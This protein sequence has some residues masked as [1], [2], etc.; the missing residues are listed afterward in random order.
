MPSM[1]RIHREVLGGLG[2]APRPVFLDSPAGFEPNAAGIAEKAVEYYRRYLQTEL[3]VAHDAHRDSARPSDVA[4]AIAAIRDSNL[5]FAGPGSPTYALRQWRG[6]PVWDAVVRQFEGGGHVLFA[7]AAAIVLGRHALPVYEIYKVGADPYWN[8]GLDLLGR[9]GLSLAV[10][11]HF[12]D[13]SGG[14]NLDTRFCYMG[15]TRFQRLKEMLPAGVAVLGIDHYTALTLDPVRREASVSGQGHVTFVRGN[16]EERLKAGTR[17]P[18]EAL[19]ADGRVGTTT[20]SAPPSAPD[21]A[22]DPLERV[23][24]FAEGMSTPSEP[25]RLELLTR[26]QSLRQTFA[27]NGA[28]SRAEEEQLVEAL[29]GLR[30]TL[31]QE[32]RFDL[33]DRARDALSDLGYEVADGPNGSTWS[34]RGE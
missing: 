11:P 34:R 22:A 25:E 5:V 6:S 13:T 23:I 12:N 21:E 7:S 27:Q 31:R 3:H 8:D 14:A 15:T 17:L 30:S 16:S 20:P 19:A 10:I 33:A 32:K 18:F 1:S 26:L 2:E 28:G 4:A 29:V 9:L 24:G